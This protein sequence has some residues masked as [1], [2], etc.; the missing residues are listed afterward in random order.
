MKKVKISLYIN[1][2]IVVLTILASIIMFSG[3]KFMKGAEPVL[4]TTGNS[5]FRFFTVDSNMFMAFVAFIFAIQEIKLLKGK[6]NKIPY[7]MYVLKLMATTSVGLTFFTVCVYLGPLSPWGMF[8]MYRNSNLFFHLIIPGLSMMNFVLFEKT[9]KL[10]KQYVIYGIIPTIIYA[11]FYISNVLVHTENGT[12]S[13]EYDWYWFV[14]N[15]MWLIVIVAPLM[16]G[17]SYLIS[18]VLWRLNK[19]KKGYKNE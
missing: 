15:G 16:L 11:L 5:M 14:Q 1:I 19:E 2:L 13:K 18:L 6:T 10:K 7:N 9:A 8:S 4:E 12:V 17:I 3:F